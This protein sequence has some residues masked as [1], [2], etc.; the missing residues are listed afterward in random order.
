MAYI[1]S[2]NDRRARDPR[3]VGAKAAHLAQALAWGFQVPLGYALTLEAYR[4]GMEAAGLGEYLQRRQVSPEE[5]ARIRQQLLAAPLPPPVRQALLEAWHAMGRQ[6]LAVRS[7][8]DVEDL[9]GA[10]FAGQY[11]SFLGIHTE[12]GLEEAVRKVWASFWG[13]RA[14]TYRQA[15]KVSGAGR[16]MG[17]LLQPLTP[18]RTSGVTFTLNPL[19][20]KETEVLIEA[21]WGLGEGVV[22]GR[23]SPD[24]FVY[25]W[26]RGEVVRQEVA[27]KALEA[28]PIFG[29]GI[30]YREVPKERRTRPVLTPRE[31]R[32]LIHWVLALQEQVGRPLDVEWI[33]VGDEFF[34]IQWRPQTGMR[35]DRIEGQWTAANFREVMPGTVSFLSA[36]LS[37]YHDYGRALT[38]FFDRIGLRRPGDPGLYRVG[39]LFYGHA[40][41]DVGLVK[42]FASRVPGYKE[43]AF[44][45]TVG[46]EPTY[47]GEGQVTPFTPGTVLRA[48]PILR[49]LNQAYRTYWKEAQAYCE[50]F[51]Q[52]ET[53]LYRPLNPAELD[54]E[55]LRGWTRRMVELHWETNQVAM[56]TS[57]LAAQAQDDAQVALEKANRR[58]ERRGERPIS[59]GLLLAGLGEVATARPLQE[60][61]RL[62]ARFREDQAVREAVERTTDPEDLWAWIRREH[63]ALAAAL[64]EFLEAYGHFSAVDEDL[65][66][67]RW[68]EDPSFVIATFRQLLLDS[69]A[70]DPE[71][72]LKALARQREAEERRLFGVLRPWER[73][74][75]RTTLERVRRYTWW[76]EETRE[77]LARTYAHNRK[78]FLEQARRWARKGILPE[79]DLF[80]WLSREEVLG[81][82]DGMVDVQEAV[83]KA[84]LR[85]RIARLYRRFTPPPTLGR[86]SHPEAPATGVRRFQGI[87]CG[88][89]VGEGEAR[90]I[91]TLEEAGKMEEGCV[92]VAPYTNPG[93][94]PLFQ[95]AAGVV[96]EEGG[97]LSHGA[98]VARE[99]GIPTV[100]GIR[101][102]TR[103]IRDGERVRVD[104]L[105]G[106][107]EV[108][109]GEGGPHPAPPR[110]E[111]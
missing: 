4:L 60:L 24:R 79:A 75:M 102:A 82:L 31:I 28:I 99:F 78:V 12:E 21:V 54:D 13:E 16:G 26:A 61:A 65:S 64:E 96:M 9:E 85:R 19:T 35:F 106:I 22:S 81:L 2:L 34:L 14:L 74:G 30:V 6:P 72:H 109:G 50:R 73:P 100:L 101:G 93:W 92:L 43:R 27:D 107:V 83:R 94:T 57:F 86:G 42:R 45:E 97:L 55:A 63:R 20:V 95:L 104:G 39:R 87:P 84:R 40:Y 46:I 38:E 25:D 18:A 89:G 47:E 111:A 110:G 17:V 67:P 103:Q 33:L 36:S 1:L 49:R 66:V 48:L 3:Q 98:V 71:A 29:E 10:S 37:L 108:E 77:V 91:R 5:G 23:I 68:R 90:V 59:L 105:R 41:W 56:T 51:R 8:A 44:D 53:A 58:L 15:R 62:A 88:A 69:D 52:E 32:R 11:D 76:R 80:F 7:S 70:P